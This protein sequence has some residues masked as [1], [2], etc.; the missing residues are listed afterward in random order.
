ESAQVHCLLDILTTPIGAYVIK[1]QR[2]FFPDQYNDS[3]KIGN[4][5]GG[6]GS[7]SALTTKKIRNLFNYFMKPDEL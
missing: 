1:K 7:R 4:P 3:T 2:L 5:V 6:I